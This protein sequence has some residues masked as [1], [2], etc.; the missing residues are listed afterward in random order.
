MIGS[1]VEAA[2]YALVNEYFF[3]TTRKTPPMFYEELKISLLGTKNTAEVWTKL[4]LM[5]GL[6]SKKMY[7][8]PNSSIRVSEHQ[9][10]VISNNIV[11]N[12]E[13]E[14]LFVFDP[15]EVQLDTEVVEAREKTFTVLDD[16]EL[17]VLGPKRHTLPSITGGHGVCKELHFYS[18]NR[19]DGADYITDCVVESELTRTQLNSF[20]YSDSMIRFLVERHLTSVGVNGRLMKYY[21]SGKPKYRKPNVVHVKRLLQEKDNNIYKDTENIKFLSLSIEEIIEQ[22]TK[23]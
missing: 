19:V 23:R 13:F 3:I 1:T 14:K 18:S 2:Y 10:K 4:N 7:I 5:L 15:T 9:I 22:S 11:F 21:N 17:S 6:L 8:Q 16:F 20:D 12:Y